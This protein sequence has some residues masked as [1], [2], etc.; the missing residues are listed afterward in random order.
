VQV[1]EKKDLL[2]GEM[3]IN[4]FPKLF[5]EVLDEKGNLEI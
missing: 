4:T 5:D 3:L 2:L 1:D